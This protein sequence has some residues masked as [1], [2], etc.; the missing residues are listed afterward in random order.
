MLIGSKGDIRLSCDPISYNRT[1]IRESLPLPVRCLRD[2]RPPLGVSLPAASMP[3]APRLC[4]HTCT[5]AAHWPLLPRRSWLGHPPHSGAR[6]RHA[7]S[8]E[9]AL[10]RGN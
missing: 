2:W 8:I 4:T 5:L 7:G 3:R 6:D 1:A 10:T 9:T